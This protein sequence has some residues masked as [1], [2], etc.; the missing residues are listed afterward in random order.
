MPVA[1]AIYAIL[2]QQLHPAEAFLSLE[3]GFI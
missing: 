1:Q 2:W 3:K